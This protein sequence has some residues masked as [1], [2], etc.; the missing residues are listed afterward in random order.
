MPRAFFCL[1]T[2]LE[3]KFGKAC[4]ERGENAGE[5]SIS[6]FSTM[7]FFFLKP[8]LEKSH[9]LGFFCLFI[10]FVIVVVANTFNLDE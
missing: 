5:R 1:M 4:G 6:C 7:F 9:D 3:R 10:I 2:R 8:T